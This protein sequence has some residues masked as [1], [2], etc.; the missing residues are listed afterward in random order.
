MLMVVICCFFGASAVICLICLI[1]CFVVLFGV[2]GEVERIVML[3]VRFVVDVM[4]VVRVRVLLISNPIVSG[5]VVILC[6]RVV[7]R[8]GIVSI[9]LLVV[10]SIEFCYMIFLI[11][12]LMRSCICCRCFWVVVS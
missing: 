8:D 4:S 1:S 10:M 5:L 12:F 6:F 7:D 2:G 11:F 3:D 9:H